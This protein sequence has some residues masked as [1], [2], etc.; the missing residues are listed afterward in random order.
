MKSLIVILVL[1]CGQVLG[2]EINETNNISQAIICTSNFWPVLLNTNIVKACT[3]QTHKWIKVGSGKIENGLCEITFKCTQ[4]S[5][6][7]TYAA[8]H[9]QPIFWKAP[10]QPRV[11]YNN[12]KVN[13]LQENMP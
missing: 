9:S 4:C 2:Q 12:T 8:V 10:E 11:S 6:I 13:K 1:I 5:Q 3:S 7:E